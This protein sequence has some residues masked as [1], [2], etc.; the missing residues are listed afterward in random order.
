ML[1]SIA[2]NLLVRGYLHGILHE[3][4]LLE[5]KMSTV[6]LFLEK[7]WEITGTFN[8][9]LIGGEGREKKGQLLE[10]KW[11]WDWK[12]ERPRWNRWKRWMCNNGHFYAP[13]RECVKYRVKCMYLF[14]EANI[15]SKILI[16]F[17]TCC[18]NAREQ[19]IRV[20]SFCFPIR[21]T[22]NDSFVLS[23]PLLLSSSRHFRIGFANWL[24]RNRIPRPFN[25]R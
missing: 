24:R 12:R 23:S 5:I 6:F 4:Q 20:R 2:F 11:T 25:W 18:S 7:P 17:S 9:D 14:C 3:N 1:V 15:D 21:S 19:R 16:W 22:D 10:D 13:D 8:N